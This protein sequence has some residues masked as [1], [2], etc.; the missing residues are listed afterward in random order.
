MNKS[1]EKSKLTEQE[2]DAIHA[3]IGSL[4]WGGFWLATLLFYL[5]ACGDY[6]WRWLYFPE[7]M[8]H[9]A[10]YV[11]A[12]DAV[13]HFGLILFLLIGACHGFFLDFWRKTKHFTLF[14]IVT[15]GLSLSLILRVLI[16]LVLGIIFIA[17]IL[18]LFRL[19]GLINSDL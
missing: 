7:E 12:K 16:G 10:A 9:T 6:F 8:Q 13:I 3:G 11:D 19:L 4:S 5:W 2:I 1:N 17:S 15:Q 14:D 18:Y